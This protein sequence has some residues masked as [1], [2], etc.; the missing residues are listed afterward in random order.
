MDASVERAGGHGFVFKKPRVGRRPL[1]TQP[2]RYASATNRGPLGPSRTHRA[3]VFRNLRPAV[4]VRLQH[5]TNVLRR[6]T[7]RPFPP[8]GP[9]RK[10]VHREYHRRRRGNNRALR[11]RRSWNPPRRYTGHRALRR[12]PSPRQAPGGESGGDFRTE[13]PT[14]FCMGTSETPCK[15][16]RIRSV[17]H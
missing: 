5:P 1:R 17:A 4:G 14:G 16:R 15:V 11:N 2:P 6:G 8:G 13:L 12:V 9:C 3:Q 10:R 7:P